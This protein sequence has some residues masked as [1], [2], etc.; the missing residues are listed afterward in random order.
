MSANAQNYDG[1]IILEILK[2]LFKCRAKI[3]P[4]TLQSKVLLLSGPVAGNREKPKHTE[5]AVSLLHIYKPHMPIIWPQH[6][7]K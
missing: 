3:T 1:S 7:G 2:V 4:V 6:N 5:V